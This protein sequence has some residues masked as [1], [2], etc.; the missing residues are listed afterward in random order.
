MAKIN[1]RNSTNFIS[2]IFKKDLI[3]ISLNDNQPKTRL[4]NIAWPS[5]ASA[6]LG[7]IAVGECKRSMFYKILGASCT[8][9][10]SVTG[11]YICDAGNMYEDYHINKFKEYGVYKDSQVK[12]D[13]EIPNS[14]N[15]VQV[16]GRMDC[17]I[18][19]DGERSVLELKSV[20]EFKAAKIMDGDTPLPSPSNLMQAMLYKYYTTETEAGKALDINNVYLMYIN[21][22]TGGT[23]YYKVD[24]DSSGYAV[25]TAY[26]QS[27]KERFTV[28]L[29]DVKSF[30]DL[31]STAGIATS[32][33]ARAAE[34]RINIQDIFNKL[35]QIYDYTTNKI[36]PPCDY[37]LVYTQEQAK[38]EHALGR[39]SKIKLNKILKGEAS[40]DSKCAYCNY[41]TKCMADNGITLK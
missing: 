14:R 2:K 36:L 1:L 22:S 9:P 27:G 12:M 17:I 13:F 31:E 4:S 30:E 28:N 5:E 20:S 23:F 33:E 35:D 34:L 16:H 32:D 15:K 6:Q 39:L 29:K 38:K 21:R 40:G 26:D 41:R 18:E 8:E 25:L 19:Q 24:L 10:M 7:S 37:S 3:N 11:R